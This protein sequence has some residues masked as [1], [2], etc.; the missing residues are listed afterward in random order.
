MIKQDCEFMIDS[1]TKFFNS[2][3]INGWFHHTSDILLNAEIKNSPVR[4]LSSI[5][6]VNIRH[7]GV[8]SLGENK[9]FF[10]QLLF[11]KETFPDD[12]TMKFETKGGRQI[13]VLLNELISDRISRFSTPSIYQKFLELLDLNKCRTMLDIGGRDRSKLDRSKQFP[14]IDVTV[15]D[16]IDGNNVDVVGD[17][18]ELSKTFQPDSFDS[19]YS[20]CVFEHILMPWKVAVEI[21]KILKIGGVGMIFTHQ[22]LGMHDLPWDFWRFSSDSWDSIFNNRTGFEIVDRAMD[23]ESYILPFIYRPDKK[24]AERSAGYEGTAVLVRKIGNAT[25]NW[26]VGLSEI[27]NTQYPDVEDGNL[28]LPYY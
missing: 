25:V 2:I 3:M 21:N 6:E 14:N 16:I 8:L 11:E 20:V 26:D 23:A 7:D 1:C 9:G 28:I 12:L 17:A 24:L 4:I 13:E 5:S 18:H 19:V 10:I 27:I 15:L 22:T